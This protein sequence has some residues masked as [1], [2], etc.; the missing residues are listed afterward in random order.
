LSSGARTFAVP[1][2]ARPLE[3]RWASF[4]TEEM[5]EESSSLSRNNPASGVGKPHRQASERAI[6]SCQCFT[7]TRLFGASGG[8]FQHL[9]N[10]TEPSIFSEHC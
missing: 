10:N 7:Q 2:P 4:Q 8:R 9:A 1:P 3:C 5:A 6:G